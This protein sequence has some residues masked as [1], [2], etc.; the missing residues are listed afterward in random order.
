LLPVG[1]NDIF[2]TISLWVFALV[3]PLNVLLVLLTYARQKELPP[4]ARLWLE[5]IAALSTII[6]I[7]LAFFFH[8]SR[9]SGILFTVISVIAGLVAFHYVH[10][11]KSKANEKG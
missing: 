9:G 3:L 6:G 4:K 2:L 5:W 11:P 1:P 8:G 10:I 7:D